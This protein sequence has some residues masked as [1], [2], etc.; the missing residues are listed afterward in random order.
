MGKGMKYLSLVAVLAVVALVVTGCGGGTT[1]GTGSTGA[2]KVTVTI[3]IGAPL[4]DGAV[5]LG[6]GMVRGTQLAVK[7]ANES[8]AVTGLGLTIA[9][10]NG[11]DKG[12]PTTG[13]NVATQFVSNPT[14]VGVMGHLN[15]GVTRVAVKIYN[16]ANIVQVSPANT[17]VDLTQMGYKNYFRVCTID[18]VQGPVGADYAFKTA[19]KKAAFVVDDSTVYG[20][21][22]ADA[23]AK[24]FQADGGKLL[25]REKTSDK[26][27]DFKALVTKIKSTNPDIV[28]YGGV[29]NAGALLSKQMKDGGVKVP[30]MGGDGLFDPAYI[31]LAGAVEASGDLATSVGLPTDKLPEGQ[32]FVAAYKAM[33]PNDEIAAYDAYSYDAANVI[34]KAIVSVAQ[35]MGADKVTTT[36]GKQAIIAAVAKTNFD[37]VTGHVQFDANGDTTNK[38]ITVYQVT[39]GAWAAVQ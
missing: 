16:Q 19:G 37:G 21:G 29:Y 28:Y 30:M 4:T 38:A 12:D 15:S 3:G 27:T 39:N 25:G 35:S 9:T 31:K 18:S 7:Q 22:L 6:Q 14:L 24:Q 36:A 23:W 17:A 11:D 13:G 33:F 8:S 5:A 2:S 32:Q 26:D 10:V 20:V 1:S 34:I